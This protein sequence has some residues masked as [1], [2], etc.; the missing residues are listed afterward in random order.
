MGATGVPLF[1]VYLT[2]DEKSK[3]ERHAV[4][5]Q[6]DANGAAESIVGF[7]K[8][9]LD[10][11]NMLGEASKDLQL[12]KDVLDF[13]NMLGEANRDM[14]LKLELLEEINREEYEED[15]DLDPMEEGLKKILDFL[16]DRMPDVKMKVFQVC[17]TSLIQIRPKSIDTCIESLYKRV[18]RVKLTLTAES[19]HRS[20]SL[21]YPVG[22]L[23]Q[24][25]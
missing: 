11:E 17:C 7:S 13:E 3:Y 8:D 19:M 18:E 6:R 23:S 2:K 15:G 9:V 25:R 5:L 21:D 1:E 14:Q 20:H 10:F 22:L 4:Y 12:S 24:H 16:K